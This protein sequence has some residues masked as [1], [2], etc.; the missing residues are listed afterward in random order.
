MYN[1]MYTYKYL[2]MFIDLKSPSRKRVHD[3]VTVHE[4]P[5]TTGP[6]E[7]RQPLIESTKARRADRQV[8]RHE[9][10]RHEG[11]NARR[12]EGTRHEGTRHGGTRHEGT[13]RTATKAR[14]TKARG[15]RHEATRHADRRQVRQA[16]R[17]EAHGGWGAGPPLAPKGRRA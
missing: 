4:P 17:Y 15:T 13:R 2:S 14:G 10:R 1:G 9:A 12:H 3:R 5:F 8:R 11:T 16:R 7:H 6:S